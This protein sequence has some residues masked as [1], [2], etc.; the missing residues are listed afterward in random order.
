MHPHGTR[1]ERICV[2]CGTPFL[3]RPIEI[4]KG[5]G[6]YCSNRC[7][8]LDQRRASPEERLWSRIPQSPSGCWEWQGKRNKYGYGVLQVEGRH[9]M[10]HRFAY[11]LT[12]G[13]IPDGFLIC[14]ICDN[15]SCCRPDHLFPG[16]MADNM[17]DACHK[18]RLAKGENHRHSKLNEDKVR[19]IRTLWERGEQIVKLASVFGV[20]AACV[21]QVVHRKLWKHVL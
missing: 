20:S 8:A 18:G 21:G 4:A 3:R 11:E 1:I 15:P 14:H 16:T 13:P 6:R 7:K 5:G 17:R 9:R 10:A 19:E 2:K 12:Y